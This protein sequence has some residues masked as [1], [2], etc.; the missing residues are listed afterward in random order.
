MSCNGVTNLRGEL[1]VPEWQEV[2]AKYNIQGTII[3]PIRY[4]D[5]CLGIVLLSSQ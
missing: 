1:R 3:L 2:A 4:K 5:N